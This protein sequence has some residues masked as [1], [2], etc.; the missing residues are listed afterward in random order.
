MSELTDIEIVNRV[1]GGDLDAFEHI[2]RRYSDR[3]FRYVY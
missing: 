1:K 2:I 3:V